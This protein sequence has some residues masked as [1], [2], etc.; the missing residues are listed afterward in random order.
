MINKFCKYPLWE[1]TKDLTATALGVKKAKTVIKDAKL[2]NVCTAEIIEHTDVAIAK[3]RIA[4]V[5]DASHCIGDDTLVIDAK[6][7]YIAPGF[8]D[9]HIHVESSMMT[10]GEYSNAVVPHGTVGIHMDPHEIANVLGLKGVQLMADD[11]KRVPLKAMIAAPSCVPAVPGFE[12][13]GAALDADDIREMMSWDSV[14]TL[15]E[16]MN[17]P[18]VLGG[19][20]NTHR[21]L[22]ETLKTGKTISGH[23]SI[24]DTGCALSAYIASG[25][26]NCHESTRAE[27]ALAKMRLGMYAMMRE[28]SAWH[29]LEEVSRAITEFG[30]DPRFAVLVSDDAHPATLSQSGHLDHIIR[31]AISFGIDPITAIQMVTINCATCFEMD[32]DMGSIA[33]G[34]CADIVFIKDL[35]SIEVTKV[36]IDGELVAENGKMLTQHEK[37][38]Y[39]DWATHTM[40]IGHELTLADFEVKAPEWVTDTVK[41]RTIEIIPAKTITMERFFDL[42]VVDGKVESDTEQDVMKTIVFERHKATG[43]KGVG[44]VKGFGLKCG[45]MAQTLS[46]DAHNLSVI[47]TNDADML[48]AAQTL[49][50]CGGGMCAVKD[51]KVLALMPM[52]IAGLMNDLPAE[53][54]A[55]LA[56][57]LGKGW[58]EIGCSIVSPYMTMAIVPLACIPELRLTNRGIVDC[59]TFTFADLFV[60]E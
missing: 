35:E 31:R 12:D 25:A 20:D 14:T 8:V 6:G 38:D 27:D 47:G 49:I 23:F 55:N 29:D 54:M 7:Q 44:F 51:G 41:V 9:G 16:M 21:E 45:A 11:G 50:E 48:L 42:K 3:G 56:A 30:A 40:N 58:K 2:I 28:G 4:L 10:V 13:T 5:G 33:P 15:G 46:H 57:N 59:R 22:A 32:D 39:P 52:P 17:F 1:V 18:G 53:E 34:K 36:L 37:Y 19:D 43:T 24:P 26:R 60:K